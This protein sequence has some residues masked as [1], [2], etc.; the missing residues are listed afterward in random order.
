MDGPAALRLVIAIFCT[1]ILVGARW[2]HEHLRWYGHVQIRYSQRMTLGLYWVGLTGC[3]V[4]AGQAL[5]LLSV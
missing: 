5:A 4:L 3:A 2:R 1:G